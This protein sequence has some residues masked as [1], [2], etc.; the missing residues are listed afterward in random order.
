MEKIY[1]ISK[2]MKKS[3]YVMSKKVIDTSQ[4]VLAVFCDPLG[5]FINC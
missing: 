4:P 3:K 5:S 2:N 1:R